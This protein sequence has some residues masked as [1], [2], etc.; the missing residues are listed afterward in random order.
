MGEAK[1][2]RAA[3][4]D[5]EREMTDLGRKLADDGKLI[6]AGWVGLRKV[7]LPADAPPEQVTELRKAFMAGAAHLFTSIMNVLDDD[8]EP[9][10]ADLRRMDQ[11]DKELEAFGKT[12]AIDLP[13]E[14]HG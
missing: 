12:L 6:D 9:T 3:M 11:I 8:R 4:T 2:R 13:V 14:G 10:E 5:Y 1:K 7:W